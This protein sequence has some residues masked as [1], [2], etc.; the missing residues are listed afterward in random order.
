MRLALRINLYSLAVLAFALGLYGFLNNAKFR[1][2][3]TKLQQSRFEILA[4]DLRDS[5][6]QGLRLGLSLDQLENVQAL[7][8]RTRARYVEV[9]AIVVFD[10][11]GDVL[12]RS[13][14]VDSALPTA[15]LSALEHDGGAS[16]SAV[17]RDD[18]RGV[19]LPVL[20]SF[21]RRVGGVALLYPKALAGAVIAETTARQSKMALMAL[22]AAGVTCLL[23]SL[24]LL[25][26]VSSRFRHM[27]RVLGSIEGELDPTSGRSTEATRL[28]RHDDLN[29]P[30]ARVRASA[31][32]IVRSA[33]RV[34][35]RLRNLA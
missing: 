30:L 28:D 7:L 3:L 35:S 29:A 23:L 5:V 26:F 31:T 24:V 4:L 8:D 9:A 22:A 32:G 16:P 25:R 2:E 34:E 17:E 15:W 10:E 14:G 21:E 27:E 6:E 13:G 11:F 12:Y 33:E 1:S 18:L 20:N 19:L